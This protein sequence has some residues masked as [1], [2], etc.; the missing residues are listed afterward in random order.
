VA[1]CGTGLVGVKDRFLISGAV[2]NLKKQVFTFDIS[3]RF[4][5]MGAVF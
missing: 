1:A 4:S 5:E 2:L 3:L